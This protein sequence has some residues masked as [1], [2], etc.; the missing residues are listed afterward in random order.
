MKFINL[1]T[2]KE[3]CHY[4]A[5]ALLKQIITDN[6]SV[7]GLATGGTMVGVYEQLVNLIKINKLDLSNI[8]TFNL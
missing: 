8:T 1:G 4:V 2:E 3:A 5:N 7:L 6:K